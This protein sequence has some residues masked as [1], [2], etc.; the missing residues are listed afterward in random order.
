M[1]LLRQA[2]DPRTMRRQPPCGRPRSA[3]PATRSLRPGARPAVAVVLGLLTTLAGG[4]GARAGEAPT[5]ATLIEKL[6]SADGTRARRRVAEQIAT[7]P[8]WSFDA[9]HRELREGC[10]FRGDA[11]RGLLDESRRTSDGLPHRYL[12]VV[13]R[14]YAPERP[15][16]VRVYLHGGVSRPAW[17]GRASWWR[18][19]ERLLEDD[20]ISV[21]P[22]GWNE[23]KWWQASQLESLTAI[24]RDVRRR[25]NVD[26]NRVSLIGRSDGGTGVWY[27]ALRSP[28][29][30]ASYV[31]FIGS[32][33]VL[34]NPDT[35][36][37]GG[38]FLVNLVGRRILALNGT[39]DRLYPADGLRPLMSALQAL[40]AELT[41][42]VEEG[43]AHDASW[44]PRR[45]RQIDAFVDSHP[46]DPLPDHVAWAT[47][48]SDE[49]R[50]SFWVLIDALTARADCSSSGITV[51]GKTPK[52]CGGVDVV[53]KGNEV[54]VQTRGVE[55]YRLLL[56]PAEFDLDSDVVVRT[57]GRESYR[58][59]VPRRVE[60][61][62]QWAAEDVDRTTLFAAELP[63]SV[64]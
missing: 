20:G 14:S 33:N 28:T 61:L 19:S 57:N 12:L 48:G 21:V 18:D 49:T 7:D 16:P 31:S 17:E 64:P 63:I 60:T 39:A 43:G 51:L 6:L 27:F 38:L 1:D 56:S 41:F 55:R 35:G 4:P 45:A 30:W 54:E 3:E 53:R 2:D 46:R 10:R 24:L 25:Y 52:R 26:E 62:L 40:G 47:D 11:K 29:P 22:A 42:E 59:R 34:A 15:S 23:S 50:R 36:V 5:L 37:E 13:P 44:W 8:R 32:P 58:G 9:V